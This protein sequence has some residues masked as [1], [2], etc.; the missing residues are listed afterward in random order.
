[1]HF[2][3][4]FSRPGWR[5]AVLCLAVFTLIASCGKEEK[6]EIPSNWEPAGSLCSNGI[7]DGSETDVDCGGNCPPCGGLNVPCTVPTG[8]LIYNGISYNIT[9]MIVLFDQALIQTSAG[10]DITI[11][12]GDDIEPGIVYSL[13]A[14]VNPVGQNA[15]ISVQE[16]FSEYRSQNG[17]GSMYIE[18]NSS[19]VTITVC[20]AVLKIVGGTQTK[21]FE[22]KE[23]E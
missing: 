19:N 12:T 13:T 1:M 17:S 22:M 15:W 11:E 10:F 16:Q 21:T 6:M 7:Q 4:S 14:A 5:K 8:T 2:N 18:G 3:Q 20:D 23:I 9:S